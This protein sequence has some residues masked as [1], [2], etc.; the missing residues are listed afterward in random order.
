MIG[1]IGGPGN[2][3]MGFS[4]GGDPGG[5]R[6]GRWFGDRGILA[7]RRGTMLL[8]AVLAAIVLVLLVTLL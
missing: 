1:G 5:P 6:R 7:G 3:G 2:S 8:L 4:Q